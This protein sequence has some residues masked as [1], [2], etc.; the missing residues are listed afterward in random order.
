MLLGEKPM[1]MAFKAVCDH[2][3]GLQAV[4]DMLGKRTCPL[5]HRCSLSLRN[6]PKADS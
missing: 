4:A 2:V 3:D 5:R 1:L 6:S